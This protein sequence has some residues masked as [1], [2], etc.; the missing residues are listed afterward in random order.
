VL[1][2]EIELGWAGLPGVRLVLAIAGSLALCVVAEMLS[3]LP[4]MNWLRWLGEHSIVVYLVF[5][6]PM[7]FSRI[8]LEKFI[9]DTTVLSL[10]V[11]VVSILASVA[12]Y[13]AVQWTGRGRFL[14]E[15][16]AWAH[17]P[18]TPGSRGYVTRPIATPAE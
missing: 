16:P 12:L 2:K 4:W 18:G 13:L 5:V 15:R 3:R 9:S 7:S 11:I 10:L 14:F 8:L 17:L 1:P 6:L